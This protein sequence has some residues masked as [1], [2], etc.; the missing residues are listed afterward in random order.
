MVNFFVLTAIVQHVALRGRN[1]GTFKEKN[2]ARH[3]GF[4]ICH[5]LPVEAGQALKKN[6]AEPF[7]CKKSELRIEL[8]YALENLLLSLCDNLSR[9]DW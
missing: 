6:S 3:R 1:N 2:C 5:T 7:W 4:M 9:R 8:Y